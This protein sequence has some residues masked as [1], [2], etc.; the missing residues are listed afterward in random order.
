MRIGACRRGALKSLHCR[1]AVA[2]NRW[3]DRTTNCGA[4]PTV[5]CKERWN[6]KFYTMVS[7][8]AAELVRFF[9][10]TGRPETGCACVL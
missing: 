2:S 6:D 9:K 1:A 3:T 5:R 10:R 7:M 4:G 8:E